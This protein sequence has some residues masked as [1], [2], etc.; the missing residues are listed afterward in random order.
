MIF[1]YLLNRKIQNAIEVALLKRRAEPNPEILEELANF[2]FRLSN[3]IE[4][5]ITNSVV[6]QVRIELK[7]NQRA[8]V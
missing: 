5:Y 8:I 6:K 7:A 2:K 4:K 1:K 3:D